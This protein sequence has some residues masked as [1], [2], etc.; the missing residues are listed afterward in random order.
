MLIEDRDRKLLRAIAL[1]QRHRGRRDPLS[2]LKCAWGKLGHVWWSIISASDI[3][4]DARIDPSVRIPHPTGVVIHAQAVVEADCIIMQQVT[5]GQRAE[6][7]A[8]VVGRGAYLGAGARILGPVRIGEGARIGANAVVLSDV[9]P[10][11]TVVGIPA[12]VVA[13]RG[14]EEDGLDSRPRP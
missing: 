10:H 14:D 2:R 4:R 7:G 12:R 5:L 11:S 8:P 13:R 6:R 1:Y 9:P 3:S